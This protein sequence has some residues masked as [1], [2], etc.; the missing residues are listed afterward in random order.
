M[1]LR[2]SSL[3]IGVGRFSKSPPPVGRESID[4]GNRETLNVEVW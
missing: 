2:F 1:C 4:G 3:I